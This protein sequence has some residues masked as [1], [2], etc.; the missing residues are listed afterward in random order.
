MHYHVSTLSR[1]TM[2]SGAGNSVTLMLPA[3]SCPYGGHTPHT[4]MNSLTDRHKTSLSAGCFY[5]RACILGVT[6]L[7]C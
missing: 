7:D 1:K 2:S 5:T 3:A 4:L 6:S